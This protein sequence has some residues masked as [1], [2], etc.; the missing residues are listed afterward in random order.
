MPARQRLALAVLHPVDPVEDEELRRLDADVPQHAADGV[1]APLAVGGEGVDDVQQQRRVGELLERG[2]EGGDEVRGEVADE[3]DGVGDDDLA[4]AREAQPARRGVEGR[5]HLVGDVRL[6]AGQ[7]PQQGALARVRIADD[8][9]DGDGAAPP[10]LPPVPALRRELL[11][12]AF[13]PGQA[14]AGAAAVDFE[15]RLARPP[16]PDAAGEPRQRD[17]GPLRE[18]RQQVLELGQLH[19]QLAVAGGR[20]LREDVEDELGAVDHP[21]LHALAE[22]AGLRGGQVLVDDHEVHVVLEGADDQIVQLAGAEH[23]PGVDPGPGLGH[24]VDDL[25]AGRAGQLAQ[26]VDVDPEFAGAAAGGDRDED[27]AFAAGG[28]LAAA[29]ARKGR[30]AVADPVLEVEGEEGRGPRVEE[31]DA[32]VAAAAAAG[33]REGRGVRERGQAVAVHAHRHHR[34]EAQQQQVGAVVPREPLVPEVRAHAAQ[35]AQAPAPGPQAAPVGERDRMGAAHHHVLHQ[36][37]AVEQHAHLASN[38]VADLGKLPRELL[39]DQPVRGHPTPEQAFE[40]ARLAGLEAVRIA[41][42]PDRTASSHRRGAA[43]ASSRA[44]R[45]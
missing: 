25:D 45:R 5:E 1:D 23:G 30:L 40:P 39:G 42:D 29:A 20:V 32:G 27:R 18:P 44:K 37:A 38:L 15:L 35:A 7:R 6:G 14:L 41:E 13:E 34:V 12:F 8:G 19:L 24:H 11:Q 43:A 9:Q 26:L 17:L 3:P 31:F 36:P 28:A 16:P 22:V 33:R 2:A 21:Q 4:L 10:P